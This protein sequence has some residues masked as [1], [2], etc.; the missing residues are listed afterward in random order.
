MRTFSATFRPRAA[1]STLLL[2]P[3]NSSLSSSHLVSSLL[4]F[5]PCFPASRR[6]FLSTC[7]PSS[8]FFLPFPPHVY[9]LTTNFLIP[10]K[11]FPSSLYPLFVSFPHVLISLFTVTDIFTKIF[12]LHPLPSFT[13]QFQMSM[14][15]LKTHFSLLNTTFG[16]FLPFLDTT[17][18]VCK[19]VVCTTLHKAT[20][21][22]CS[23]TDRFEADRQ[24]FI[25]NHINPQS[26]GSS[27]T[28]LVW[29]HLS[30]SVTGRLEKQEKICS[31]ATDFTSMSTSC[32][33]DQ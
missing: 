21:Y 2:V 29:R 8:C 22:N 33:P 28:L 10:S 32:L 20:L 1:F 12:F 19:K 13:V 4:E 18:A 31:H 9:P 26:A 3:V 11:I 17:L 7:L 14:K 16:H 15:P 23:D 6:D 30:D 24:H 25:F 27:F 5:L